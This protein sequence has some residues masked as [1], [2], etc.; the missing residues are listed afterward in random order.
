MLSNAVRRVAD[1]SRALRLSST[2]LRTFSNVP[3]RQHPVPA[4]YKYPEMEDP[5]L[6]GYPR[7]PYVSRQY[8]PP[9][10]WDDPQMRRNFG[11]T[12]HEQEEILSMWG[13]DIPVIAPQTALRHF[14]IALLGFAGIGLFCAAITPETPCLRRQYPF[15]G[16]EKELGGEINKARV[17]EEI[18]ED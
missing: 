5:Q 16:L 8:L 17:E 7:L 14:G 13:P 15:D 12:L 4:P 1:P 10:G 11:D 9:R 18:E 6:N 3:A 2:S